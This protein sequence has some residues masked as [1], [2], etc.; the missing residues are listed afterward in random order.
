MLI[1]EEKEGQNEKIKERVDESF[2]VLS[3]WQDIL[4][5]FD[6]NLFNGLVVK[7]T[8]LS[9]TYFCFYLEKWNEHR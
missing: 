4:E 2:Q 9:P 7:I 8:I 3:S 6:D 1:L 5:R